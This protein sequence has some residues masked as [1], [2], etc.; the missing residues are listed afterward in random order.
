MDDIKYSEIERKATPSQIQSSVDEVQTWTNNSLAKLNEDKSKEFRIDFSRR[1]NETRV[2]DPIFV[3]GKEL[4]IGVTASNDLK[5]NAHIEI[6][7]SRVAKRIYLITHA[8][9]AGKTS[10]E[11]HC[12]NLLCLHSSNFFFILKIFPMYN[13]FMCSIFTIIVECGLETY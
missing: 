1:N 12:K 11:R 5:W 13:K 3:N 2:F 8:T 7:V 6:I 9:K 10:T 4:E